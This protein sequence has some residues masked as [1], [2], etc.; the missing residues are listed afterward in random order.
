MSEPTPRRQ[1]QLDL[2][3][4]AQDIIDTLHEKDSHKLRDSPNSSKT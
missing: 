4:R 1:Q 2:V 3:T